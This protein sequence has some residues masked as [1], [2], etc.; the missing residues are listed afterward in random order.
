ME[1]IDLV[2]AS[3]PALS[4]QRVEHY[5]APV[6]PDG[7]VPK[8]MHLDCVVEDLDEGERHALDVGATKVAV[9]PGET[10]RVFLDPA[11]HRFCLILRDA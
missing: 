3:L 10:F 9:Q 8:Q 4:F 11:G 1:G 7:T 5:V 2:H 6:W